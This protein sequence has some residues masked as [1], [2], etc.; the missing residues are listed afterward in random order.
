MALYW[1]WMCQ[2]I[3]E[4]Y[5]QHISFIHSSQSSS[6]LK[7]WTPLEIGRNM[8]VTIGPKLING[9]F[10]T[11]ASCDIANG[12]HLGPSHR[13]QH[14]IACSVENF[15]GWKLFFAVRCEGYNEFEI[16]VD[17]KLAFEEFNHVFHSPSSLAM[18]GRALK[19]AI[20]RIKRIIVRES[21]DVGYF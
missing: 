12:S 8:C 14:D 4:A 5:M 6:A 19:E 17:E 15:K 13:H 11:K 20:I 18:I 7:I 2:G 1:C 10:S 9:S 3:V 16:S 21:G